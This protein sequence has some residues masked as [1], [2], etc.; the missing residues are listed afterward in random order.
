[1]WVHV[2]ITVLCDDCTIATFLVRPPI[3][4]LTLG[5]AHQRSCIAALKGTPCVLYCFNFLQNGL[6]TVPHHNCNLCAAFQLPSRHT[7]LASVYVNTSTV[8]RFHRAV[9][10]LHACTLE[11]AEPERCVAHLEILSIYS[12]GDPFWGSDV[13]DW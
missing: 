5:K 7:D 13:L 6:S 1:M 8:A 3:S 9:L 2:W 11:D 12:G 10:Q 4:R